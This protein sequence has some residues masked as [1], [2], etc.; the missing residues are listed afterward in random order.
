MASYSHSCHHFLTPAG[1]NV[2]S[3]S[4]SCHHFLTP[5]GYNVASCSH[6]HHHF[7]DPCHQNCN[8]WNYKPKKNPKLPK[9][10]S[11]Q[12]FG[13]SN[14][15]VTKVM[16]EWGPRDRCF[17]KALPAKLGSSCSKYTSATPCPGRMR[18]AWTLNASRLVLRVIQ[19]S[20]RLPPRQSA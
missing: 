8:P 17:R 20:R 9:D 1:Y 2:A 14:E 19:P 15:A 11:C 7:P 18:K 16:G 5:A 6:S 12:E 13:H 3:Y 10:A 4:H